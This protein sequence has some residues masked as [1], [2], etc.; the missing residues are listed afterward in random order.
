[1]FLF[2]KTLLHIH[3]VKAFL[4]L[5]FIVIFHNREPNHRKDNR[6]IVIIEQN[7]ENIYQVDFFY[8]FL[9]FIFLIL[10]FFNFFYYFIFLGSNGNNAQITT[11]TK[12]SQTTERD[13]RQTVTIEQNDENIYQV[14]FLFFYF[15]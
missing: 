5:A 10:F 15:F 3:H 7:A 14:D 8:F 1:M 4:S 13:N 6:Q 2:Y 12:M 11:N 9:F